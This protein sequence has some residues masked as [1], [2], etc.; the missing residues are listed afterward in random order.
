M[1]ST[2]KQRCSHCNGMGWLW[3]AVYYHGELTGQTSV[4]CPH[5]NQKSRGRWDQAVADGRAAYERWH[6]KGEEPT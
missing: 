2:G 3:I 4:P 1:T 5:C 6:S